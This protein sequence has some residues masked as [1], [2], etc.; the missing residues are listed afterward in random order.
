MKLR[1][2]K[3]N[4]FDINDGVSYE[5]YMANDQAVRQSPA[6]V[7]YLPQGHF[8]PV[9]GAKVRAERYITLTIRMLGT[10][11][12]QIDDLKQILSVID[13]E[14][15]H[16]FLV[17]DENDNNREYYLNAT[18]VDQPT[19]QDCWVT[20]MLAAGDGV[21]RAKTPT[22]DTKSVTASGDTKIIS[23]LGN[24]P[25]PMI[26]TL[27]PTSA[28]AG[29]FEAIIFVSM[30]NP[31]S[32]PYPEFPW[33]ITNGGWNTAALITDTSK[34]NQLNGGINA[35]V[36]TIDI[37][38][39]VGGGLPARG[40]GIV[41][42]E[43]IAWTANTGTQL[44]NV[45][46]G[47]GGTTAAVHADNAVIA[48]SHLLAN[49]ADVRVFRG[50][51]EI[52]F[53]F[54]TGANAINQTATKIWVNLPFQA[55]LAMTLSTAISNVGTPSAINFDNT[56]TNRLAFA[57]I[58]LPFVFRVDNEIFTA[59]GKNDATLELSGLKRAQR[60]TSAAT[61]DVGDTAYFIEHDIQIAYGNQEL[62]AFVPDDDRKPIIALTSTNDVWTFAEFMDDDRLRTGIW[63]QSILTPG[64]NSIFYGGDQASDA[65]PWAEMGLAIR[66]WQQGSKW[67][68][69]TAALAWAIYHPAG[70]TDTS[71]DGEKYRN[72]AGWPTQAVGLQ[73][74]LN[75]VNWT[76]V[77]SE[78]SPSVISTFEAVT[79][80]TVTL[81]GSF[82]F[83]RI[84]FAG[85]VG[86]GTSFVAYLEIGNATL[87]FTSGNLPQILV[88]SPISSYE[89]DC[90]IRNNTTN[91]SIF[92]RKVIALN[93]S[94][95]IDCQL[96]K[97]TYLKD[98]SRNAFV[99]WSS[100]RYDWLDLAPGDNE[101][102]FI[103]VGT[104][105]L[106]FDF[107]WQDRML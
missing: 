37:D 23:H 54:G 72:S 29:G 69:E 59:T 9:Y 83:V 57:R 65:D 10:P 15:E 33:D 8:A 25:T 79:H 5:C 73:K 35:V 68:G 40:M 12:D 66:A 46:R 32:I 77:W 1:A 38:T 31:I 107:E 3:Y 21:Y 30:Y 13:D 105:A 56:R 93:E 39:A 24:T 43:Q 82:P 89:I 102:E 60:N 78:T 6:R 47:V 26:M 20:F 49:G 90:Q 17:E 97:V 99:D 18:V 85:G 41:G 58:T 27:T 86:A 80:N 50:G 103:D 4:D 11:V 92:V 19:V 48:L 62:T 87:T 96:K 55:R 71:F 94:L 53:W 95:E 91:K 44:Q 36:T 7:V 74:S 70:V 45:T 34:S 42:T 14:E 22:T 101:I 16:E 64:R 100:S 104:T 28:K 52:D 2:K 106:T 63:G 81:S 88:S 61:H 84:I 51:A 75:G 76:Q 98:N 67:K